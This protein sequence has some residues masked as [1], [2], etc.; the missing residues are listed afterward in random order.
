[1]RKL[2]IFVAV[3][4]LAAAALVHSVNPYVTPKDLL[5]LESA[6]GVQVIGRVLEVNFDGNYTH[7]ILTDGEASVRVVYE[8]YLSYTNGE[9]VAVGDWD[10]KVL[11]AHQILRKCHTEYGV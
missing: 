8:G 1:M 6:R 9:I 10:G 7:F 11:R 2:L 3:A 4:A 5:T